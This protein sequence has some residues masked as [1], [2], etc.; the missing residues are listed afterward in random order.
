M[1]GVIAIDFGEKKSGFAVADA[2]RI[3]AE[4][5]KVC[6][7]AGGGSELL[8]H[9]ASLLAERD[10]STIVVGM[11]YNMDGT[12]GERAR[13]VRALVE[14]IEARFPELEVCTHDERLT[15]KEAEAELRE[16]G[17]R[18]RDAKR[19]KDSWSALILLRDWMSAGEPR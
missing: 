17:Y 12:E 11:P 13:A 1:G 7:A 2:L 4:P 9:L 3:S 15:T 19:R 16:A 18:G 10:V 6:R 8:D 14:R 5:L